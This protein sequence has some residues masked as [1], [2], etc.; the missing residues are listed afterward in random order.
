MELSRCDAITVRAVLCVSHCHLYSYM[1]MC[2]GLVCE[3]MKLL[4]DLALYHFVIGFI[5]I[6]FQSHQYQ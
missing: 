5:I 4:S 2:V 6:I 3:A 1:S